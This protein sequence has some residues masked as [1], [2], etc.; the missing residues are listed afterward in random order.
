MKLLPQ[1]IT[2]FTY[3]NLLE[4]YPIYDENTTYIYEDLPS[5]NSVA[6]YGTYYW[7]S[8]T[9]NNLGNTP[10]ED[11]KFWSRLS[12]SN[13]NAML[14]QKSTSKSSTKADYTET[15]DTTTADY[16]V[17]E[18]IYNS[19]ADKVY[20]CIQNSTAGILLTNISFFEESTFDL[21]V[22]F[23]R[24]LTTSI[25]IGK[26][27][28]SQII[29]ENL[30]SLD[31][32]VGTPKVLNYSV[33]ENVFDYFDYIYEPYSTA[34]NRDIYIPIDWIGVKVRVTIK[35]SVNKKAEC[36]FLVGGESIDMGKTIDD[37]VNKPSSFTVSSFDQ[38]GEYKFNKRSAQDIVTFSTSIQ[39]KDYLKSKRK[40]KEYKDEVVVFIADENENSPF[41][42]LVT[43]GITQSPKIDLRT[44]WE[45]SII[46]WDVVEVP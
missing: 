32:V 12:V 27:E 44:T 42:N 19:T 37:Y 5:A 41:D 24:N 33:N 21:I 38:F 22:E 26:F 20:N 31:Q 16:K 9:N 3:S 29:I 15:S 28:A 2:D 23:E 40:I 8:V 4:D 6:R 43:L 36:G 45:N 7:K 25:V 14:D 10:S 18:R 46:Q 30:D 39:T 35:P 34:T 17:N 13:R 11:S 1:Q